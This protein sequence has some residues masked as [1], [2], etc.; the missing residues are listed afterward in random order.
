MRTLIFIAVGVL[1]V[2]SAMWLVRPGRRR[3]VA[4]VFS[5]GWLAAVWWNLRTGMSHG[6][7]LQEELP[8]QAAIYVVPV[9]LAW[10]LARKTRH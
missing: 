7:S 6:Y 1:L 5:V 10:W 3:A 4:A 2:G 9:A 8:I